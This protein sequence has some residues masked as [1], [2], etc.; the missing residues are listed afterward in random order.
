MDLRFEPN[1][2]LPQVRKGIYSTNGYN[3]HNPNRVVVAVHPYNY[4]YPDSVRFPDDH[5]DYLT[6]LQ[7]FHRLVQNHKGPL[8]TLESGGKMESTANQYRTLGRT[9]DSYFIMTWP[10][11]PSP[12]EFRDNWEEVARF[13]KEFDTTQ[14]ICLVGG[15][16]IDSDNTD[17]AYHGC[18]GRTLYE[19]RKERLTVEVLRKV[20]FP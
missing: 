11:G 1:V 2:N 17:S 7:R 10:A 18:L 9:S 6:Y 19:L 3:P 13:L 15:Q 5:Q 4:G 16:L 14:T 8:V 20:T 12:I